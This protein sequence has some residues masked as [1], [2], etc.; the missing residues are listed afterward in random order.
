MADSMLMQPDIKGCVAAPWWC[1]T[2]T[3]RVSPRIAWFRD[4][5]LE[6]GAYVAD[7]RPVDPK[8]G[9]LARSPTRQRLYEEGRY[10]P[11]RALTV[12]PRAAMLRWASRA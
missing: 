4:F 12:W 1:S 11:R 8:C 7:M 2:D 9:A 5:L 3:V 10:Q 6:N